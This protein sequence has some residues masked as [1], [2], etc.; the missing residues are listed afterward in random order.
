MQSSSDLHVFSCVLLTL[1]HFYGK[2]VAPCVYGVLLTLCCSKGKFVALLCVLRH[3]ADPRSVLW[4]GLGLG[5]GLGVGVVH[6][7]FVYFS[8]LC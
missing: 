8:M 5:V 4:K 2:F 3:F 1:C 6:S 7:T